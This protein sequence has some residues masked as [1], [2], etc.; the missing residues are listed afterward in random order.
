MLKKVWK[1]YQELRN[2]N[3]ETCKR[4]IQGSVVLLIIWYIICFAYGHLMYKRGERF[5]KW[6]GN[7]EGYAKRMT[8]EY[9][10]NDD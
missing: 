2:E 9:S 3:G 4:H 10:R 6:I 7:H 1:D 8:E 5:G